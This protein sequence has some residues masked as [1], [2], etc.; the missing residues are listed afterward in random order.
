MECESF[1]ATALALKLCSGQWVYLLTGCG[2]IPLTLV[3]IEGDAM[4]TALC[5]GCVVISLRHRHQQCQPAQ[6]L[7]ELGGCGVIIGPGITE[8]LLSL[9]GK[10]NV[11]SAA[12]ALFVACNCTC[13][14]FRCFDRIGKN[15]FLTDGPYLNRITVNVVRTVFSMISTIN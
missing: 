2:L 5:L 15:R 4:L 7:C 8:W 9:V 13:P 10:G 3:S 6:V 11:V 14:Q 12:G 1:C